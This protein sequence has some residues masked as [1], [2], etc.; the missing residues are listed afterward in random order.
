MEIVIRILLVLHLLGF[1]TI[2]TGVL[3]Q[4]KQFKTGAKVLPS[5]LHGSWLAMGAGLIMTGLLPANGEH[6]NPITISIK[7]AVITAIFFI[8]YTFN[9]KENT[10]KWVV[11]VIGLLTVINL[12][13][14]V[15]LGVEA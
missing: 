2:M 11:P 1:A 5:I 7:S 12:S 10:P 6:I 14:A 8:A 15:L 3:S 9:K 4:T 13:V